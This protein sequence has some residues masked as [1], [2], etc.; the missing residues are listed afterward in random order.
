M[1]HYLNVLKKYAVFSGRASRAEY[2]NFFLFSFLIGAVLALVEAFTIGISAD[3]Q[4]FFV[5]IYQLLVLIPTLAVTARRMHDVDKSGWFMFIPI[6]NI[7]LSLTPGTAGA[8]RFGN[9]PYAPDMTAT[10]PQQ[11]V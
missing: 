5:S 2:W 4:S 9:D 8:N 11:E 6:Y 1:N 10:T 7:I 3:G